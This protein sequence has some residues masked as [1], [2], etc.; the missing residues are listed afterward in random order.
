MRRRLTLERRS[1]RTAALGGANLR[2]FEMILAQASSV[3]PSRD[4]FLSQFR[5]EMRHNAA[6]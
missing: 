1:A 4:N 6:L 2:H 3:F 5:N